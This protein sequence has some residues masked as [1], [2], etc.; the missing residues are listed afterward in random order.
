VFGGGGGG[1]EKQRRKKRDVPIYSGTRMKKRD[2][3]EACVP[4]ATGCDP[5]VNLSGRAL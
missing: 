1:S 3:M 5:A 4:P 2:M